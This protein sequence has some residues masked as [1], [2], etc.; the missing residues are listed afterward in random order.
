MCRTPSTYFSRAT[1]SKRSA[2]IVLVA[3]IIILDLCITNH[4]LH[5]QDFLVIL[6]CN[7]EPFRSLWKRPEMMAYRQFLQT[8][9]PVTGV[10]A[11]VKLIKEF[12]LLP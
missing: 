4:R 2:D 7:Y 9:L 5:I 3:T 11:D 8:N 1:R 10:T 12:L 6:E